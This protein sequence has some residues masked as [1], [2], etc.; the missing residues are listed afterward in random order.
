MARKPKDDKL[1]LDACCGGKM[2][3][4]DKN[5]PN[6]LYV[7]KR[8]REAGH[9]KHRKN[10]SILPDEIVDFTMMP[11]S[12]NS[13]KMVVFDPPHIFGKETGN[14]TKQYGW[15]EKS[16]WREQIKKGF[17]ECWRVLDDYGTLIFKW[18]E[19]AVTKKE[20]IDLIGKTP[21]FGHQ[22]GGKMQ[23]HWMSFMKIPQEQHE[24]I[25]PNHNPI[26]MAR[27]PLAEKTV[28]ENVLKYGTG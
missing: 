21:L 2:F 19:N 26:C 8:V 28:A 23:T 27:K 18:N 17:D 20:I 7:D 6:T 9:C 1:I 14:M 3:W 13:F 22:V 16:N 24:E 5:H 11:F 25:N 15:L 12:D 4:F 10:H